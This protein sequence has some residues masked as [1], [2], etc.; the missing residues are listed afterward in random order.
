[1]NAMSSSVAGLVAHP[2]WYQQIVVAPKQAL[3]Y[4]LLSTS[5]QA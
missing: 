2:C 4:P 1:M 3:Q 5:P